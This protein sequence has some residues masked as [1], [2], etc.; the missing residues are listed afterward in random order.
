MIRRI[1]VW[2]V[3]QEQNNTQIYI[4]VYSIQ[5]YI[6]TYIFTYLYLY[7][8]LFFVCVDSQW[9]WNSNLPFF[10][11][12]SREKRSN[13]ARGEEGDQ[14]AAKQKGTR[15]RVIMDLSYTFTL[16]T[17]GSRT[18]STKWTPFWTGSISH[19][20]AQPAA[21]GRRTTGQKDSDPLQWL[22]GGGQSSG[23]R[24][25]SRQA[26]D[27]AL[28]GRQGA[29]SHLTAKTSQPFISTLT[30]C[31]WSLGLGHTEQVHHSGQ[32]KSPLLSLFFSPLA[33]PVV[34]W[35]SKGYS[36]PMA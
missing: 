21:H 18:I 25:E 16:E 7:I 13:R 35:L 4:C 2:C 15:R 17:F 32:T 5:S 22:R 36:T 11:P 27:S 10:S 28:G 19:V 9:V 34:P 20:P 12:F 30:T 14:T 24:Q 1:A 8:Y 26:L 23:L 29:Y 6:Y 3:I 33:P 31:H